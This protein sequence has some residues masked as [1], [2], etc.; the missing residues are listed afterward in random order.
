MKPSDKRAA[1]SS[2]EIF[3]KRVVLKRRGAAVIAIALA[4]GSAFADQPEAHVTAD[5]VAVRFHT[6]DMGGVSTPRF[7]TERQVSFEARLVALEDDPSG[8]VQERHVHAAIDTHI[9]EEMLG[10]L[11]LDHTPDTQ[12]AMHAADVVR[13]GLEQRVGGV[14]AIECA[15]KIDGIEPRELDAII[16]R[17]ARALI[18]IDGAVGSILVAGRRPTPRDVSHDEPS[19]SRSHVRR[20]QGGPRTLVRHRAVSRG[21]ARILAD[22]T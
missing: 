1:D 5:S 4:S 13:K 18:Y 9:A 14:A 21:A 20:L 22:C 16:L 6:P 2:P 15:E 10:A 8:V 11:P 17:E 3:L 12:T 19:I 7:I